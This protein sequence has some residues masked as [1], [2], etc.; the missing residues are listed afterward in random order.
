M[1]LHL[2]YQRTGS[3]E[4]ILKIPYE[5]NHIFPFLASVGLFFLPLFCLCKHGFDCLLQRFSGQLRSLDRER[6]HFFVD[7]ILQC[8]P[9]SFPGSSD[10]VKV[11]RRFWA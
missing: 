11:V 9:S 8:L 10:S 3:L 1:L 2:F 5:Y 4:L 6:N 7:F